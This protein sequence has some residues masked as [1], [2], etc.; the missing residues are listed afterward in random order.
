M[1][2][3]VVLVGSRGRMGGMLLGRARGACLGGL[4]LVIVG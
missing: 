2:G 4:T 3:K 1:T